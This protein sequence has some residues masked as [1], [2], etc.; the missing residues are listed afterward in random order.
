MCVAQVI[1]RIVAMGFWAAFVNSVRLLFDIVG[2]ILLFRYGL[3][4]GVDRTVA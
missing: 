2:V 1:A 3:P 4:P